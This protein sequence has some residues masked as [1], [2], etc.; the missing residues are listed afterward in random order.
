MSGTLQPAE[1]Y[2]EPLLYTS[3]H[4]RWISTAPVRNIPETFSGMG[5]SQQFCVWFKMAMLAG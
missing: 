4:R 5:E 1:P 2:V 3:K